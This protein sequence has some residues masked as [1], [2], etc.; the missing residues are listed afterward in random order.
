MYRLLFMHVV[1]RSFSLSKT[2]RRLIRNLNHVNGLFRLINREIY[3][4]NSFNVL[5]YNLKP[6]EQRCEKYKRIIKVKKVKNLVR[7]RF[8]SIKYEKLIF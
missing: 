7:F 1:S 5:Y 6:Y 3:A 2:N 8:S 4:F